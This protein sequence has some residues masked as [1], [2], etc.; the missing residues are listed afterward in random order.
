[1]ETFSLSSL[2]PEVLEVVFSQLPLFSLLCTCSRVCKQ[3]HS[4]IGQNK[5]LQWREL[6]YRYKLDMEYNEDKEDTLCQFCGRTFPARHAPL[7]YKVLFL[8]MNRKWKESCQ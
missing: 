1:M 4:T 6:Y 2:P 5:F 8:Q 7:V 3:W